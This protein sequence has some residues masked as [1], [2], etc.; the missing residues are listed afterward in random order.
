[1]NAKRT[2]RVTQTKAAR[3]AATEDAP[4]VKKPTPGQS[5]NEKLSAPAERLQGRF[6]A[7]VVGGGAV[8]AATALGLVQQG[9][10]VALLERQPQPRFSHDTPVTRV[11]TLNAASVALLDRLAVW[12]TVSERRSLAFSGMEVWDSQSE[13][14]IRFDAD[15]VGVPA[16]GW[17]VELLA[18]EASLWEA[19]ATTDAVLLAGQEWRALDWHDD[20]M[21]VHLDDG[22]AL[23]ARV[24]LAADGAESRLRTQAGIKVRREP[25]HA[26]GVVATVGTELSHQDTAWQRFHQDAIVAFL[27]LADGRSSIVWSQPDYDAEVVAALSDTDFAAALETAFEQRLGRITSVSP[28]W[29][30]PLVGRQARDYGTERLLLL[31]DAAHTI[32]PLA[33]QGLNL[34][35][36]DVRALLDLFPRGATSDPG[37]QALLREFTRR[38]RL[39]NELMLRSMEGLR[40]LFRASAPTWVSLRALGLRT[41]DRSQMLKRFFAYR[42]LGL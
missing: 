28:R 2:S 11:T 6:D 40:S 10:R 22:R 5:L 33:G 13:A 18:L 36:A 32:H 41:V 42:A 27:P 23:R 19:L 31:G 12:P 26:S 39:E 8:G 15:E 1:M 16:L 4:S 7:L 38:R 3:A 37:A 17:T 9:H 35:L 30:F 24:V 21:V 20:H 14:R 34:G 25:Y 29:V